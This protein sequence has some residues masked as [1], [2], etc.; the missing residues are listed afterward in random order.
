M[1][2]WKNAGLILAAVLVV[3]GSIGGIFG[4]KTVF[5]KEG[6]KMATPEPVKVETKTEE[7]AVTVAPDP[8]KAPEPAATL[9]PEAQKLQEQVD[10]VLSN[11]TLRE[12]IGQM[13]IVD[14]SQIGGGSSTSVNQRMRSRLHSY[15]VGGV[16]F[17]EK[18]VRNATQA[19]SFIQEL[20]KE[21]D[22]PLFVALEEEG[23]DTSILA[24]LNDVDMPAVSNL[25]VYGQEEDIKGAGTAAKETAKVMK[26]LGFN[27]N[28]APVVDALTNDENTQLQKR[29]AGS[30]AKLAADIA[31]QQILGYQEEMVSVAAKY[32]PGCGGCEQDTQD[33][34]AETLRTK[35]QME[36]EEWLPYEAAIQ[37]GADCIMVGN[38]SAPKLTGDRI[39]STLST[40]IVTD[41]L[42]GQL[43]YGGV[44]ISAP[45]HEK[46]ITKYYSS[47]EAVLK[48]IEAGVDIIYMPG[49]LDGNFATIESAVKNGKLSMDRIDQSVRRILAV[50][51]VRGILDP[52]EYSKPKAT[53]KAFID[54]DQKSS[55]ETEQEETETEDTRQ[56]EKTP[57]E[58]AT[59]TPEPKPT[60]KPEVQP[61]AEPAPEP[62]KGSQ[63]E[64]PAQ[65][66]TPNTDTSQGGNQ[67]TG[68]E[69]GV[70]LGKS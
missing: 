38:M 26:E 21:S 13:F 37:S 43:G 15:P 55:D 28:L 2:K 58:Q 67:E 17:T 57:E 1:N 32:F 3:G 10:A 64:E 19:T 11:M 44:V 31:K 8:T 50:K 20:Q 25:S 68:E 66:D 60:P 41:I 63:G 4:L 49:S 24:K 22:Y 27:L 52:E 5:N 54:R 48:A 45:F 42:R 33:G 34:Y 39:P 36:K 56:E 6:I 69:E 30:D 35:E 12:K 40:V 53:E 47:S 14:F 59:P 61:T 16:V 51:I 70:S 23:G 7:P 62:S 18:N 29:S 65:S 9:S 46:A